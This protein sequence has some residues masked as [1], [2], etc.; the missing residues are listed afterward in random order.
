[1]FKPNSWFSSR[2]N[3]GNLEVLNRTQAVECEKRMLEIYEYTSAVA[4]A[5]YPL[6]VDGLGIY[7]IMEALFEADG[8]SVESIDYAIEENKEGISSYLS[9]LLANDRAEFARSLVFSLRKAGIPLAESDYLEGGSGDETLVYVK[10]R[11]ADEAYDVLSQDF[12]DPRVFYASDF[13]EAARAV[14]AGRAEYCLLP[15][16]EKGGARIPSISAMLFSEDLKINSVTPVFGFDGSADMKYALISRHFT[17]PEVTEDDDRYL[18]IRL[19]VSDTADFRELSVAAAYL[20]VSVYRLNTST[21]QSEEGDEP[22]LSVVFS[23]GGRD[24]CPLLTYLTLFLPSYT[25]VG[26]Y[27]NLE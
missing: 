26:I 5:A 22:Y 21:F 24:F 17:V 1:M 23:V 9:T 18:E 12:S 27:N 20:G 25:A 19:P 13:K 15:L 3:D 14:S 8:A 2:I 4:R 6:Y 11:L 16:E 10:N 7:E